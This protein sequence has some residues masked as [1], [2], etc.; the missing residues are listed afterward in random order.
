MTSI[1]NTKGLVIAGIVFLSIFI[2]IPLFVSAQLNP[3]PATTDNKTGIT[4]ECGDGLTAGNC[5]FEDLIAATKRLTDFGTVFAL[6]FSVVV[7]AW[8]GF[9]Y[10][11]SGD[12]PGERKKANEMFQKVG[13]GILF[14][15]AAWLIISLIL[16]GLK[17]TSSVNFQ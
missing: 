12:N 13:L 9:K 3:S 1:I 2:T 8:A 10:M 11:I 4:Y 16:N 15:L 17:V 5:S 6:E 14:I 7:I